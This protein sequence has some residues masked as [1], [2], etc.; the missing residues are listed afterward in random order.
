E[1]GGPTSFEA[2]SYIRALT[3]FNFI[4]FDVVE[5]SPSYDGPGAETALFAST[6]VFEMLSLVQLARLAK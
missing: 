6:T 3:G 4:G 2:L 1:V 5:V